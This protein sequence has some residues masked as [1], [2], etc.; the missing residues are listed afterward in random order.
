MNEVLSFLS[1]LAGSLFDP[2]L[3]SGCLLAGWYLRP[4][5]AGVLVAIEW[6]V[7]VYAVMLVLA[8]REGHARFF[9]SL[10]QYLGSCAAAAGAAGL[11]HWI[12][13]RDQEER[14]AASTSAARLVWATGSLFALVALLVAWVA[15][16]HRVLD[17]YHDLFGPAYYWER[18]NLHPPY[19]AMDYPLAALVALLVIAMAWLFIMARRRRQPRSYFFLLASGVYVEFLFWAMLG[20]RHAG[21]YR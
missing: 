18:A 19:W 11:V 16:A 15:Y 21:N 4:A 20:V 6:N 9:I 14:P 2:V 10:A 7:L 8:F 1:A 17:Y 5:I 3:M 12:A 13:K